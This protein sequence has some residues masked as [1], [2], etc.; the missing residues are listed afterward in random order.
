RYI[1]LE[2]LY[3]S[4]ML[5]LIGGIIGLILIFFG[6]LIVARATEFNIHLSIGNIITG[7]IISSVV[8]LVSGLAPALSAAR[9][10]PVVAIATTF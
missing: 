10:N 8:G 5:S 1:M 3:E 6:T 4:G 7:L 9:L 2:V